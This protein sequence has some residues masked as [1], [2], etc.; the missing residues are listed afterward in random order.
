MLILDDQVAVVDG[1]PGVLAMTDGPL[2]TVFGRAELLR[3][4]AAQAGFRLL[5]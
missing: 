2:P 1:L 3:A 4:W 5:K